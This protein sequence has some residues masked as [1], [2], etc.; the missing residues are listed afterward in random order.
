MIVYDNNIH[1]KTRSRKGGIST[2]HITAFV[3]RG[4]NEQLMPDPEETGLLRVVKT[5][6]LPPLS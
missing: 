4:S 3:I 1:V 2:A 5:E 6:S